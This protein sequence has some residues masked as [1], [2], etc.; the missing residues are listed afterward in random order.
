M[1]SPSI[2]ESAPWWNS[3]AAQRLL[4]WEQQA[5]ALAVADV[6]GF[7]ALQLGHPRLDGLSANRMPHR[8]LAQDALH[9]EVFKEGWVP[10]HPAAALMP[11]EELTRCGTPPHARWMHLA[12][13]FDAL[14]FPANSIDLVVM[15]HTLDFCRD[16]H[17]SLREVERVLVPEGRVVIV[18][19]NPLSAWGARQRV[20]ALMQ[21]IDNQR[22]AFVPGCPAMIGYHR[23]R[24]WLRLLSFE[25]VGV[26][27]GVWGLPLQSERALN[28]LAWMERAGDRWWPVLGAAYLVSAVK[29]VRAVRLVGPLRKARQTAGARPAPAV[30]ASTRRVGGQQG[31]R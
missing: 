2:L 23:L 25:T 26:D 3:P 21:W 11:V 4:A 13:D 5:L 27:F 20:N 28:R 9:V 29:R 17:L 19:F 24:D 1:S 30:A 15:P 18:G 10:A 12:C 6:F 8:W 31:A 22:P 7:H 16:P 14:P